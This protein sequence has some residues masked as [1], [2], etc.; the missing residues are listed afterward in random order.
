MTERV[1]YCGLWYSKVQQGSLVGAINYWQTIG[2]C[3]TKRTCL[4][5]VQWLF[6][7][8]AVAWKLRHSHAPITHAV[9]NK[10]LMSVF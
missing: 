10:L 6:V 7:D 9:N 2:Y 8:P 3:N 1:L 5:W 4:P